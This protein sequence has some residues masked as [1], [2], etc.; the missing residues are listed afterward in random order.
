[1]KYSMELCLDT[2][3]GIYGDTDRVLDL[4]LLS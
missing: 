1:M 2:L 3:R 4:S